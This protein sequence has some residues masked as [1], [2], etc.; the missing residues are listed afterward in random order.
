MKRLF[1]FPNPVNE[2]SARLVAFGNVVMAALA[3]ALQQEW[4]VVAMAYGFVAHVLAG[5]TFSPL[6]RL[7][8]QGI[9]P[10]LPVEKRYVPGPPK[11]FA[12]AIGAVLTVTAVALLFGFGLAA[13]AWALVALILFFAS[14]ESFLGFCAGCEIFALLLRAGL[15]P[16][17]VCEECADVRPRLLQRAA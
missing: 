6:A 12:Q 16:T 17:S 9:T 4:L 10:R 15:I 7:V 14:L 2:V 5:P 8:M 13:P 1:R 11:R 3:L